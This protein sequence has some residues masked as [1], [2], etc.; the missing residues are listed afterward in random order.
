[1]TRK[2]CLKGSYHPK[3]ELRSSWKIQGNQRVGPIKLIEL[4]DLGL[5]FGVDGATELV[6]A[7]SFD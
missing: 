5:Y 6:A 2:Y 7:R 1:L 3:G 4:P